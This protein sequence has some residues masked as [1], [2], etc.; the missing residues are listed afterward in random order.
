MLNNNPIRLL[1]TYHPKYDWV[2]YD[3]PTSKNTYCYL[4]LIYEQSVTDSTD[5]Y[6]SEIMEDQIKSFN[7]VADIICTSSH[8]ELVTE[9]FWRDEIWH[10]ILDY[11]HNC[12]QEL[13]LTNR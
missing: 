2:L 11:I 6:L 12:K 9:Q 4:S 7:Q 1:S 3:G 5:E 10:I 13:P 8:A